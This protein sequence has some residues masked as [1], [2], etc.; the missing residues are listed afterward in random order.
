MILD[1]IVII[2]VVVLSYLFC[3]HT[4]KYNDKNKKNCLLTHVVIGLTVIVFY[5]LAK[6]YK[7]KQQLKDFDY[8]MSPMNTANTTSPIV[9]INTM[10]PMGHTGPMT[11]EQF[12]VD[13]S[14][15]NFITN[16]TGEIIAANPGNLDSTTLSNYTSKINDLTTQ[17]EILNN[18][19]TQPTNMLQTNLNT[20]LDSISLENQ[21]AY[22]QMQ[23]NFLAKQIKNAQDL[24]NAETISSSKQNYKPIK[25]FSSCVA[26]ADGSLTF[27]QP[28]KSEFQS[29]PQNSVLNSN[30]TKQIMSTISQNGPN[31]QTKLQDL[32]SSLSLK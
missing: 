25:V 5:K 3:M 19:S 4:D 32:L 27:D 12:T 13:S 18:N 16:N 17:L 29:T 30:S 26:N 20:S 11:Y 1:L 22:Q 8:I 23:I 31:I 2:L 24:I 6:H 9:P 21:Q 7:I 14:I 15:S 28:I 10:G